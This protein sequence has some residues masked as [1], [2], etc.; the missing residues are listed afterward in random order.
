MT[1]RCFVSQISRGFVDVKSSVCVWVCDVPAGLSYLSRCHSPRQ[2]AQALNAIL[3]VVRSAV[4]KL[5][6]VKSGCTD[7]EGWHRKLASVSAPFVSLLA[8]LSGTANLW[9]ADKQLIDYGTAGSGLVYIVTLKD[10][11]NSLFRIQDYNSYTEY[12]S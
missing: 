5:V 1:K 3:Y 6:D 9:L 8:P 10:G 2:L 11:S 4:L 7:S 12:I